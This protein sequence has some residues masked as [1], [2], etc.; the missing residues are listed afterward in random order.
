MFEFFD[1]LSTLSI[2]P[3]IAYPLRNSD[4]NATSIDN[5]IFRKLSQSSIESTTEILLE[6]F[7]DHQ[8]CFYHFHFNKNHTHIIYDRL[9]R[10]IKSAIHTHDN[11]KINPHGLQQA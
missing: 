3:K 6:E 2:Y 4:H 8:P 10:N 7:S 1:I 5:N 11:Y 9:N